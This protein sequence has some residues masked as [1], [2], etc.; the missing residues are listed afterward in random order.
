MDSFISDS[1]VLEKT[2]S[3]GYQRVLEKIN[4]AAQKSGRSSDD[5]TLV[6]VSKFFPDTYAEMAYTL[7]LLHLGENKVQE[8]LQKKEALETRG[9]FPF[10]H[11]IGTLQTNKVRHIVGKTELIHS[12]DTLTLLNEIQKRSLSQ[13]VVTNI[14]L[15]VNISE[16]ESKHGFRKE[17]IEEV[18]CYAQE[19]ASHISLQGLMTMAPLGAKA[20]ESIPIFEET[21]ELFDSL[22][23]IAKTKDAWKSLSF[24]M[25]QD[26]EEAILCGST[27]VRV[28]T[29]IFGVRK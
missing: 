18:F 9:V 7:G 19:N 13:D 4:V 29:A 27:H 8:L 23:K 21:K 5:V 6:G 15:Q 12:I 20:E 3:E 17:E 1:N 2:I 22:G 26:Y 10:W 24:G 11:L 14:L 28:G 25:S 16:E